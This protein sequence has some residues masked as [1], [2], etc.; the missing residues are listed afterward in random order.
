M[1]KEKKEK[2]EFEEHEKRAFWLVGLAIILFLVLV[3]G[4]IILLRVARN[5][6]DDANDL[7]GG[8][9]SGSEQ[10][11]NYTTDEDG[12]RRNISEGVVDAEF[13]VSGRS[14]FDFNINEYAGISTVRA[15]VRNLTDETLPESNFNLTFYDDNGDELE[16]VVVKVRE[17][18]P[19]AMEMM[20]TTL[21]EDLVNSKS[22]EV[23][24]VTGDF[25]VSE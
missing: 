19:Q 23:K 17:I 18:E 9:V 14:F 6:L 11:K 24:E 3:F 13:N 20:I 1:S 5:V 2:V 21:E 15:T 16:N 7:N 22:I 12:E 25:E 10:N 4:G 8:L